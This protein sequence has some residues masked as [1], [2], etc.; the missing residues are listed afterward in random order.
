MGFNAGWSGGKVV[1]PVQGING[2]DKLGASMLST[3]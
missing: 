3:V 2:Y 1:H